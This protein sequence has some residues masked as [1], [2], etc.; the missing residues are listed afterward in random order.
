[1]FNSACKLNKKSSVQQRRG[2]CLFFIKKMVFYFLTLLKKN[3][4]FSIVT[5]FRIQVTQCTRKTCGDCSLEGCW[6]RFNHT[7][8]ALLITAR[9]AGCHS[10]ALHSYSARQRTR[11][12]GNRSARWLLCVGGSSGEWPTGLVFNA[13][14]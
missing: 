12:P 3:L 13:V 6:P 14:S 10:E 4:K 11:K 7:Q 1:M 2:E 8:R 9:R 5:G